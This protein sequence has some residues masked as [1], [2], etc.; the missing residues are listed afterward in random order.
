MQKL[1][2][3]HLRDVGNGVGRPPHELARAVLG[4]KASASN[5][6]SVQVSSPG[7][8]QPHPACQWPQMVHGPPRST[9]GAIQV[10]DT[11]RRPATQGPVITGFAVRPETALAPVPQSRQ[12]GVGS[13]WMPALM[14]DFTPDTEWPVQRSSQSTV[15]AHNPASRFSLS[16]A[17]LGVGHIRVTQTTLQ[18]HGEGARQAHA[19]GSQLQSS[20]QLD[21][22]GGSGQ[23]RHGASAASRGR[24]APIALYGGGS[25]DSRRGPNVLGHHGLVLL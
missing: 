8:V 2:Q 12:Q 9:T 22:S 16:A 25:D 6:A 3:D 20:V 1:F 13:T 10:V 17:T 21:V 5:V 24:G 14:T 23:S 7:I 4:L 18:G 19:S 15:D 11:Q